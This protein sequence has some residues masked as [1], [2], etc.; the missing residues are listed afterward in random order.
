MLDE[1]DLKLIQA[2]RENGRA[3]Y[4]DLAKTLGV[5]EGTVRKRIHELQKSGIIKVTAVPDLRAL[6]Y[7][8]T[9]L[10][11]LQINVSE[12]K[13]VSSALAQKP[14]I[15]YLAFVTGRYDLIAVIISRS[16]AELARII[17]EDISPVPGILRTETFIN[18]DIVKGG[19][20][21]FDTADILN[22][23]FNKLQSVPSRKKKRM[24]E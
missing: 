7:N 22:S 12:L 5:V 4:V 8:I 24:V 18:L 1:F 2:L 6:G 23:L 3:S 21:E 20:L 19:L 9:S 10:V 15:C 14:N 17:E 16:T 13:K 11:G